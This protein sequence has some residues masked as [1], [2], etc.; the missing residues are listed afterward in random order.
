MIPLP[1]FEASSRFVDFDPFPLVKAHKI[2]VHVY[3]H[4][5]QVCGKRRRLYFSKTDLFYLTSATYWVV[6]VPVTVYGNSD[7][8]EF[9]SKF[10]LL[11]ENIHNK[12]CKYLSVQL[13]DF[14]KIHPWSEH[15][16]QEKEHY[17]QP[18]TTPYGHSLLLNLERVV[19]S[20]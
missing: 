15:P 20:N 4:R 3:S 9:S 16:D 7:A 14:P 11:K 17:Q 12:I 5:I 1:P 6:C 10:F 19:G 18:Q 2:S 13:W 8:P